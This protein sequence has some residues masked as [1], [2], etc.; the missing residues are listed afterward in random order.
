M[1]DAEDAFGGVLAE[2]IQICF[3][4]GYGA[5]DGRLCSA[6]RVTFRTNPI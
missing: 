6:K 2:L 1:A 3:H 5:G 4:D